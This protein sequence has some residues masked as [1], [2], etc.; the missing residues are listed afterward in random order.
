M[1]MKSKTPITDKFEQGKLPNVD[2]F[3]DTPDIQFDDLMGEYMEF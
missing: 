2:D 1:I 3:I